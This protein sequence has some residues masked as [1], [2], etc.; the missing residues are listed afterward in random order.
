M[1][2]HGGIKMIVKLEGAKEMMA[3]MKLLRMNVK[4]GVRK[5]ITEGGKV[6]QADAE[7]RVHPSLRRAKKNVI[8]DVSIPPSHTGDVVEA[9]IKRGKR[10]S[11][12]LNI[13]ETG[14]SS[15]EIKAQS[16]GFLVF[17]GKDGRT[18]KVRSVQHPGVPA[19]P[20]LRPAFDSKGDEAVRVVGKNLRDAIELRKQKLAAKK[21]KKEE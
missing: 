3:E 4:S 7:S 15:H 12:L 10:S 1:A 6:I 2:K 19:R 13:Y 5:A 9:R 20:W 18:V 8:N 14:A 17:E 16:G 11:P 21:A